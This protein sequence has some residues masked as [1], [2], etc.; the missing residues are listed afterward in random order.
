M[1]SGFLYGVG[2]CLIWGTVYV[3]PE[4]LSDHS[5]LWISL[6]R[7]AVFGFF[8]AL[9]LL[10]KHRE[11]ARLSKSD[12]LEAALLGV[13]GNLLYYW[14]LS[15][16]VVRIGA[17]LAAVFSALIPLTASLTACLTDRSRRGS[18]R[19]LAVPFVLIALG[20]FLLNSQRLQLIG[21][22]AAGVSA[23]EYGFGLL[24]AVLSVVI[25]TWFPLANAAW[26]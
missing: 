23:A 19:R 1:F 11:A 6:L 26:L 5:P 15:A 24:L 10:A 12:W 4:L 13:I 7:Y 20:L 25:W 22:V 17:S 8:S 2:A 16:A 3:I 21:T 18:A 14:V 9:L